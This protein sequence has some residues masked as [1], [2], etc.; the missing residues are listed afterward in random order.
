MLRKEKGSKESSYRICETRRAR[1]LRARI[2]Q[3]RKKKSLNGQIIL[4]I[5]CSWYLED[6][7]S[8]FYYCTKKY[9][10]V[11]IFLL[12]WKG[13]MSVLEAWTY[14]TLLLRYLL[15]SYL[16]ILLTSS[17]YLF[18]IVDK[19]EILVANCWQVGDT[20]PGTLSPT[21]KIRCEREI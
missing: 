16:V 18:L 7:F 2:I 11:K 14:A 17:R 3:I 15:T 12:M 4:D 13:S 5:S 1:I 9:I 10:A 8:Y 20:W 19:L 21:F 6:K